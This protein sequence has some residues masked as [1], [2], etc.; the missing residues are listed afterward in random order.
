MLLP[1]GGDLVG[2]HAGAEKT[3]RFSRLGQPCRLDLPDAIVP[4]PSPFHQG[5]PLAV[6]SVGQVSQQHLVAAVALACVVADE[7]DHPLARLPGSA[8]RRV[9]VAELFLRPDLVFQGTPLE[10]VG[11]GRKAATLQTF[12]LQR[13]PFP[14]TGGLI[15]P[16]N[17]RHPMVLQPGIHYLQIGVGV[18]MLRPRIRKE[19]QIHRDAVLVQPNQK[20][21]AVGAAPV[22]NHIDVSSPPSVVRRSA[23]CVE[24]GLPVACVQVGILDGVTAMQHHPVAD[25]N[26][27]MGHAAGIVGAHEEH[28]IAGLGVGYWGRD[29]VEPLGAQ[30]P[31]IAQA[32]VGQHIT[33]KAAAIERSAGAA[34]APHIGITQVFFRL[35][36]EGVEPLVRQVF[37]GNLPGGGRVVDVLVHIPGGREQIGAVAQGGHIGGVQGK[38]FLAHDVDRHMGEVEVFQRD[39]ADIPGVRNFHLIL[40]ALAVRPR[41]RP[42][43]GLRGHGFGEDILLVK[44]GLKVAL[45]LV[46]GEHPFMEC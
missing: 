14:L 28:Q 8:A 5:I 35:G 33:D 11:D 41:F 24:M 15:Y 1:Q 32:A 42:I 45:Y 34:A 17:G 27:H 46:N 25:I 39:G 29:I 18:G 19:D 38:L 37:S 10:A 6:F 3:G 40:I 22:G 31:G 7:L 36:N 21:G 23:V 13:Q 9:M 2:F 30:P 12:I 44:E 26:A 4:R 20:G 16:G 43:P